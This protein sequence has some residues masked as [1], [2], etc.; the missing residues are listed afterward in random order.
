MG[1]FEKVTRFRKTGLVCRYEVQGNEGGTFVARLVEYGGHRDS[2]SYALPGPWGGTVN[3]A[4]DAV[5]LA[6]KAWYGK[7]FR[8][9]EKPIYG[10]GSH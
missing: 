5:K 3:T 9:T 4:E 2:G 1:T 6:Y 8:K 10:V 7:S